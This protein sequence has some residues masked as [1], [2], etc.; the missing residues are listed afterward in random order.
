LEKRLRYS[1]SLTA[2]SRAFSAAGNIILY[3]VLSKILPIEDIGVFA[4]LHS[5]VAASVVLANF[6]MNN[7][8]MRRISVVSPALVK[9]VYMYS[10]FVTS[11]FSLVLCVILYI[12]YLDMLP[13][14]NFLTHGEFVWYVFIAIPFMTFTYVTSG[15][16]KGMHRPATAGLLENGAVS[17]FAA[18]LI[19]FNSMWFSVHLNGVIYIFVMSAFFVFC[20]SL[21][22]VVRSFKSNVNGL[23]DVGCNDS[24]DRLSY[25]RSSMSFFV[26]SLAGL[27]QNV[28][29]I[30]IASIWLDVTDIGYFKIIQQIASTMI[31]VQ[32]VINTVFPPKFAKLYKEKKFVGLKKLALL[33]ADLGFYLATPIFLTVLIWPNYVLSVFN[34][35]NM[36]VVFLLTV[37]MFSQYINAVTGSVNFLLSMTDS[38]VLARNVALSSNLFGFFLLYAL[39]GDYGVIGL[40]VAFSFIIL[41][42]NVACVLFVRKK[43]GY[44][45]LPLSYRFAR[46]SI[47]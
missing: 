30:I 6:G 1:L 11:V 31:F 7:S 39:A 3:F 25:L 44:W 14:V 21:I 35:T 36:E 45:V 23:V 41:V 26:L 10:I 32:L 29:I 12:F 9:S 46:Y 19:Y 24:V 34:V 22:S 28:L 18:I 42:N 13:S 27:F 17:M 20:V 33:S 4:L 16:Y 38:E 43:L 40:V 8:L 15:Y 37:V 47:D 5:L 2:L